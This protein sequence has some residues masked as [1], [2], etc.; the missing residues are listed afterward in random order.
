MKLSFSKVDSFKQCPFKW[1]L[2]YIDKLE[3]IPNWDDPA[4]PLIIGTAIHHGIEQGVDEAVTEYLMSYPII[5]DGHLDEV[6][7]LKAL[8]PKVK[9]LISDTAEFEVTLDDEGRFIG[10]IDYLDK[11]NSILLDFK[12][13]SE[14][15][16][17]EKYLKSSQIHL[18]K[19]YLKELTGYEVEKIGYLFI[20]KISIRQKKTENQLQFRQRLEDELA[21][22]EPRIE[23]VNYS[24][25]K[26][27][28]FF[29]T[30]KEIEQ[31]EEFPK[32]Q[33]KLC[34]WCEYQRFCEEGVNYMIALPKNERRTPNGVEL[35]KL[36]IY[37][38][39]FSGKTTLADK[40]EE[41]LMINT[42][43]NVKF[44][45]APVQ[46]ITDIVSVEGRLTKTVLAWDVFKE[47]V[48]ELEKG[49]TFKTIVVD[50]VEDLYESCRLYMY[51]QMGI[52]HESD[53]SFRA[54]D[55]VRTEFLSTM[56]K[57]TTL[58]Y[59]IVLISHEDMSKDIMKRS[60]DK[61]TS[62]R[63]NINEKVAN[64]LAGM[65]DIVVR[66]VVIDGD[67]RLTFKSDEVVFG[68]GRI[69]PKE[70]EIPNNYDTLIEVVYGEFVTSST[71]VI[72]EKV[73]E[74]PKPKRS[75]TK[76][77]EEVK[78]EEPTTEPVEEVKDEAPFEVKEEPEEVIVEDTSEP[79]KRV[80]RQRK[81]RA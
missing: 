13:T 64:K 3:T 39:P 45:T 35:K 57:L 60:G 30:A 38:S 75:R 6:M 44:V 21:K 29:R 31:T 56:R 46:E 33:S 71:T 65:V 52:S 23:F 43:G 5:T 18:Y 25:K 22:A 34:D 27:D 28:E 63:P 72:E 70:K 59:N 42:D 69:N 16:L 11:K 12:Y 1:K 15:N 54:W 53:D 36:W 32:N 73:E 14:K 19:W 80:R 51:Q 4:N 17:K 2:K 9:E 7:K 74:A 49:S 8:I 76:K 47:T 66:A 68:G 26:V 62:I 50:L 48:E 78:V 67:Y 55:K 61:I 41:P 24:Q 79:V 40:F 77:A 20:P 37:G 10:Y 81:V 58:P